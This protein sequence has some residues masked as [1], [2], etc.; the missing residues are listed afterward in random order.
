[1]SNRAESRST[2]LRERLRLVEE[3]FERELRAR[4][5]DPAQSD[6]VALTASLARLYAER[7]QLRAELESFSEDVP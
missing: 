2:Q 7:E 5:F 1:M 3:K 6:H 4:G